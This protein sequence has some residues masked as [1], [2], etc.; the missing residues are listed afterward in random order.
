MAGTRPRGHARVREAAAPRYA[1]G[2]P[3]HALTGVLLDSDVIIDILRGRREVVA[4]LAV[5]EQGGVPTY[6]CAIAWAEIYA[7]LRP[8]EE[9]LTEA[10]FSARG[11]VVLDAATGRQA[12]HFLGRYGQSH[13]LE[14]ADVF[15]AAAATTSGLQ[16]WTRN[17]RH[18]PMPE[19]RFYEP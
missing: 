4:A 11:D 7:G 19:L 2:P 17:R 10:F 6:C 12:G 8:G 9:T 5:L 13:G 16:L 15:V 3:S 14:M 1:S 18:Y